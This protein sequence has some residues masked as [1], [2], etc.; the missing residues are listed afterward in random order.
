MVEILLPAL[1]GGLILAVVTGPL[2]CFVVWR[3]MSYFGDTLAHSA[4]LGVA[5]GLLFKINLSLAIFLGCV[6]MAVILV[7]LQQQKQLAIDTLLGILAHSSLS[8]GLVALSFMPHIQIDLMG[9]LF[10]DLLALNWTDLLWMSGGTCLI[11]LTLALS[12]RPLLLITLHEDMAAVEGLPVVAL[13]L[14]LMLMMS[15]VIALAMKVVGVL[16]VTSLLIIPAATARFY[17]HTPERMAVISTFCGMLAV[18]TGLALSWWLDTPAGPSV[19]VAG[20]I[21]F[22][23][24]LLSRSLKIF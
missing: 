11:L 24:S 13:R 18:L 8:L 1:L 3:R 10:G 14:L 20:F 9:Y 4:L 12:W 16:L 22:V 6:A 15:T 23:C 2:G 19:V 17:A 7:L 5:F 21:L